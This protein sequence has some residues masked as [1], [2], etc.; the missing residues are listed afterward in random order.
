M[1]LTLEQ[2]RLHL[3]QDGTDDASDLTLKIGAAELMA[4]EFMNRHVYA[5]STALGAAMAAA[6]GVLEDATLAYDAAMASA[7]AMSS[8]FARELFEFSALKAYQAAQAQ[9]AM[10]CNGMVLNDAIKAAML[11]ILGHLYTNRED[12]ITGTIA[13]DLP[14][15]SRSLLQPYRVGMGV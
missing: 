2:A 5:D 8:S 3:R 13:T 12:V 15:G 10:T 7:G 1:L 9:I 14:M 11:L 6:P 4:A